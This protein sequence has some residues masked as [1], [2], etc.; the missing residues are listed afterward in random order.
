[1]YQIS[2][3]AATCL[4]KFAGEKAQS[5]QNGSISLVMID[6]KSNDIRLYYWRG[7]FGAWWLHFNT[8]TQWL[9]PLTN[10]PA[11]HLLLPLFDH[12]CLPYCKS[13]NA[14][15]NM[16]YLRAC[17]WNHLF[18]FRQPRYCS[19]S[20]WFTSS[21]SLCSHLPPFTLSALTS[22]RLFHKS[23]PPFWYH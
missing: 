20:F 7:I 10:S 4:K 15:F 12:L 19:L 16:H 2:P 18:S 3:A 8:F 9:C 23:F 5:R 17:L 1:M 14:L 13:P 6:L 21:Q 22:A 11:T